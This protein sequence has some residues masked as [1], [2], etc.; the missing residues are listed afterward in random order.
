[1]DRYR[2]DERKFDVP[3]G[4][5]LARVPIPAGL[6][7]SPPA[8]VELSSVYFDTPALALTRAG[9]TLR[10]RTGGT[11]AGW[12]LKVPRADGVRDELR[13]PLDHDAPPA[14]LVDRARVH[15]RDAE[16]APVVRLDTRRTRRLLY[17]S[18]EP[19]H[20]SGPAPEA[21]TDAS[22][23]PGDPTPTPAGPVTGTSAEPGDPTPTPTG[24]VTGTSTEPGNPTST[25]TGTGT[26]AEPGDPTPPSAGP[27]T[28][29]SA[30]P[31]AP[32][33]TTGRGT[34]LAEIDDDLVT[35]EILA[36]GTT[37]SWHEV[38]IELHDGKRAV[39]K[40]LTAVMRDAGATTSAAPSKLVRALGD[41]LPPAADRPAGRKAPAG[42]VVLAHL[43]EHIDALKANDPGVRADLADAVHQVR[44]ASRRLRSVLRTFRPLFDRTQTDPLRQELRWLGTVLG[45]ARDTEVMHAR[46]REQLA[47]DPHAEKLITVRERIDHELTGR[48]AQ[49][50]DAALRVLDG[51]RYF[52]LLDALDDL[53]VNPSL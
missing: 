15:V 4:F 1:M 11:D 29:A 24:A 25:P 28:G 14:S 10:R 6:V 47:S 31:T 43:R 53:V 36:D 44:V 35:A 23:E 30:E 20:T 49:A 33:V 27:V 32:P 5:R 34:P 2:E 12:H 26:S 9:I 18:P 16:L 42:D 22:A 45:D 17:A 46:L 3:E 50:H 21:G 41:R 39:L 19:V 8:V 7:V 51:E 37:T 13:E 40:S 52:R 38:E 48:Y